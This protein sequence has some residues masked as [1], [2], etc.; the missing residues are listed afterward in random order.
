VNLH[1]EQQDLLTRLG[2]MAREIAR[3]QADA[4]P[5][6]VP[7]LD[8]A[9]DDIGDA[10]TLLILPEQVAEVRRRHAAAAQPGVGAQ[11]SV[12]VGE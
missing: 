7:P 9:L 1:P 4:P 11:P 3:L 2:V 6:I 8:R 12:A 5:A 10:M